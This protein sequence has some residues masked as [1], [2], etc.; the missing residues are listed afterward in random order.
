MIQ[1]IGFTTTDMKD[2]H[3]HH[4]QCTLLTKT[5]DKYYEY[6]FTPDYLGRYSLR[7][8]PTVDRS[9]EMKPLQP[10]E[11]KWNNGK[12]ILQTALK[13]EIIFDK[14][15]RTFVAPYALFQKEVELLPKRKVLIVIGNTA[16]IL[17]FLDK[18]QAIAYA[19]EWAQLPTLIPEDVIVLNEKPF[20]VEDIITH[21]PQRTQAVIIHPILEE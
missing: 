7:T 8:N 2:G 3:I 14:N 6:V 21:L 16:A 19:D 17:P 1:V 18:Y 4:V 5:D 11:L 12:L 20:P 15:T 9:A 13:Q 10:T